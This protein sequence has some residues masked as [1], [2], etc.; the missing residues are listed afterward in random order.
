M[1]DFLDALTLWIVWGCAITVAALLIASAVWVWRD[2]HQL[3]DDRLADHYADE[4]PPPR[5]VAEWLKDALVQYQRARA[6]Y[7]DVDR[8]EWQAHP[9]TIDELFRTRT[10]E[11]G[12]GLFST[13]SGLPSLFGMR[14]VRNPYLP[15]GRLFLVDLDALDRIRTVVPDAQPGP[16]TAGM[17][18]YVSRQVP[19]GRAFA[20]RPD[21]FDA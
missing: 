11:L 8:L 5:P 9:D 12:V 15:A 6:T 18:T 13:R 14:L 10:E 7:P 1:L 21:L 20:L 4:D 17:P 16:M 19:P 2:R 3:D